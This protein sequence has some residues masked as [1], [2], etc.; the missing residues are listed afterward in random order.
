MP[1]AF[2][3]AALLSMSLSIPEGGA[4]KAARQPAL[5][6]EV[7]AMFLVQT[8]N[9]VHQLEEY[10]RRRIFRKSLISVEGTD[11]TEQE[12]EEISWRIRSDLFRH[13]VAK[14]RASFMP[15]IHEGVANGRHV[16]VTVPGGYL[17]N[18][19]PR[20]L[21]ELSERA[22]GERLPPHDVNTFEEQDIALPESLTRADDLR[23]APTTAGASRATV[24]QLNAGGTPF[25]VCHNPVPG[26]DTIGEDNFWA[27]LAAQL[28]VKSGGI[29][30][31]YGEPIPWYPKWKRAPDPENPGEFL[32]YWVFAVYLDDAPWN[33]AK[34]TIEEGA[35]SMGADQVSI[36]LATATEWE[37]E[38]WYWNS[39]LGNITSI[40]QVGS[41]PLPTY[42]TVK[43]DMPPWP[44]NPTPSLVF[45]KP[46]F[47]RIWHDVGHLP[48][49][50]SLFPQFFGGTQATFTW[51]MD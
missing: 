50:G 32:P 22:P 20:I 10:C 31:G 1:S 43:I 6:D 45:R 19:I 51:I 38:V 42:T 13:T 11:I 9:D 5:E 40:Y 3:S 37:K 41:Q 4:V 36:G 28:K 34:L 29:A 21:E 46:G 25:T 35:S 47:L 24:W 49:T 14:L 8:E 7:S 2:L 27:D 33:W 30:A 26:G 18:R 48:L 39:C 12:K 15:A 44:D 17:S 16:K 23:E